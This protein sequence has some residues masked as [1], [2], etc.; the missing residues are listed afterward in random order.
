MAAM[1]RAGERLHGR[2]AVVVGAGSG[3][4]RATAVVLAREGARVVAADVNTAGTEAL[5]DSADVGLVISS[6]RLD[7]TS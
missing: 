2:V 3:I 4:G 1:N 6:L 5:A 7:V